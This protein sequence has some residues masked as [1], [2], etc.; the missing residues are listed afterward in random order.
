MKV[1]RN[2]IAIHGAGNRMTLGG[3]DEVAKF[4]S[5]HFTPLLED[6]NLGIQTIIEW[7]EAAN[8]F[9]IYAWLP[10]NGICMY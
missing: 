9:R 6:A 1:L 3:I 8:E 10:G 7:L 5:K 2:R 4:M